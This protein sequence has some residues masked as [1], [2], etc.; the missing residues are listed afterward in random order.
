VSQATIQ[1]ST[2]RPADRGFF[3]RD[4]W[5]EPTLEQV[6]RFVGEQGLLAG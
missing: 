4:G 2:H 5:H 6:E 3:H 1:E